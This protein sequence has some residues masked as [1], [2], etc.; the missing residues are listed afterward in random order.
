[1]SEKKTA[2]GGKFLIY[3]GK[4][5]VR[6][7]DVIYYG[8]PAERYVIMLQILAK[9]E[10]ETPSRVSVSLISTNE[11]LKPKDRILKKSEKNSLY[12]ALDIGV[13]WLE[14]ALAEK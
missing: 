14:R 3:K 11:N 10:D 7:E 1:M 13:I 5:L 6:S 4:P 2:K 9:K 12:L 8:N